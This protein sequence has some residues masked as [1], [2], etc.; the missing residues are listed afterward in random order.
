MDVFNKVKN[1]VN[2][3]HQLI[4]AE[5]TSKT[6]KHEK[7]PFFSIHPDLHLH[8]R[9]RLF[10]NRLFFPSR[11]VLRKEL[12][13]RK[14]M[15]PWIYEQFD[16]TFTPPRFIGD[17]FILEMPSMINNAIEIVKN[18]FFEIFLINHYTK[19]FPYGKIIKPGQVLIDG[20]ANIG[21]FSIPIAT[22]V[23]DIKIIAFEPEPLIFETLI[24][25][26]EL[27]NLKDKIIC[28]PFGLSDKESDLILKSNQNC[29][30]MAQFSNKKIENNT[31]LQLSKDENIVKCVSL[32]RFLEETGINRCDAI[33]LDIEGAERMALVG[34]STII[35]KYNPNLSIASYHLIDDPF[36]LPNLIKQINPNY[37]IV[38]SKEAHMT[39]FV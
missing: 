16:F 32:D 5:K 33:K 18:D 25:N 37:N 8:A 6:N 12:V 19:D 9:M 29:F 34:A 3:F 4:K 20:G 39:A 35:K 14:K 13:N 22:H 1:R 7:L 15:I 38:V 21:A 10:D 2:V 31:I 27:N 23:Q 30:T 17:G 11:W 26:V 36:Y 24:K 28:Y